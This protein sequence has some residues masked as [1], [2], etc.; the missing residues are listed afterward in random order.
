MITLKLS[1]NNLI[2]LN[3]IST[4]FSSYP[5]PSSYNF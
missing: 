4:H 2:S 5:L 3:Q 1:E